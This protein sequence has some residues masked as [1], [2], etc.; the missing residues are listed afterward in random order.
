MKT[1]KHPF[2]F[3]YRDI[4]TNLKYVYGFEGGVIF[5][6]DQPDKNILIV[7]NGTLADFLDEDECNE[8][9]HILEF[10]SE[11]ELTDY[12]GRKCSNVTLL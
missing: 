9:I 1:T 8:L 4:Y 7:D 2:G 3:K 12:V 6:V 11:T 10:D 5:K